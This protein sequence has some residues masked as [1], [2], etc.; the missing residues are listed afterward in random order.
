MTQIFS[1]KK[2]LKQLKRLKEQQKPKKSVIF[3][4]ILV[5][6]KIKNQYG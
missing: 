4:K 1:L 2:R 3:V 6:K 5:S